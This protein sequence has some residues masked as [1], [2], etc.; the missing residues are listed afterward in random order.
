MSC[1]DSLFSDH[2]AL[3][4]KFTPLTHIAL[5]PPP[6]PKGYKI[7]E[8][9]WE[10]WMATFRD[11]LTFKNPS[12]LDLSLQS[13]EHTIETTSHSTLKPKCLPDPKG[14]PWW[15]KEC[16][17]THAT[18][19]TAINPTNRHK[20]TKALC[21]TLTH[22]K[23]VWAHQKLHAMIRKGRCTNLFPALRDTNNTLVTEPSR[24]MTLFHQCFFPQELKL[25]SP[26]Q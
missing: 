14:S 11:A 16:T 19:R 23:R 21:N 17:T 6:A 3:L 8:E 24:K 4:I 2:T 22:A 13:F 12:S 18:I 25:I 15:N 10:A 1:A 9:Q 26:T 5:L 20:A 7:E